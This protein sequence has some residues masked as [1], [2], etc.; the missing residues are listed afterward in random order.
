MSAEAKPVLSAALGDNASLVSEEVKR[1]EKETNLHSMES[2][3][4]WPIE[5]LGEI[6]K[7]LYDLRA[8]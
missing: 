7:R 1:R 4:P 2:P 5:Q 6:E 8:A 3:P